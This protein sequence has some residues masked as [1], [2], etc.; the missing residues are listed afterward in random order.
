MEE[1]TARVY[2]YQPGNH[3]VEGKAEGDQRENLARAC[4]SQMWMARAPVSLVIA[5]EYRRITGKYGERGV[6]YALMEAGH[7]AQNVFLQAEALG[8]GA[9]I[10]GAFEDQVVI[11]ALNLPP[12]HEPLLVMPVGYRR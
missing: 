12:S 8:L 2:H 5:A 10:V 3:A 7:A 4:Y 11:R 1:L 6:R 9:G